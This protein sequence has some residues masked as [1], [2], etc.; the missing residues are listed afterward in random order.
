MFKWFSY[1][2]IFYNHFFEKTKDNYHSINNTWFWNREETIHNIH[3][4]RYKN[5]NARTSMV[6]IHEF[7]ASSFYWRDNIPAFSK[8]YNV[9]TMDLLGFGASDKPLSIEYTPEIWRNQT[10]AFVKKIY[11]DDNQP[12]V[13]IGNNLGGYLAIH[14][15]VDPEIREMIQAVIILNPV[16]LFRNVFIPSWFFYTP[17]FH[18]MFYYFQNCKHG[19]FTMLNKVSLI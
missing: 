4:E 2:F 15:A 7:G 3:F 6:L 18:Q 9:Y 19:L 17:L 10:V 14:S 1:L 8:Q 12:V 13:L 11:N 16:G 5:P